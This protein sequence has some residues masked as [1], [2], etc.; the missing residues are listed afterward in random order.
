MLH[1]TAA[2][3]FVNWWVAKPVSKGGGQGRECSQHG[4]PDLQEFQKSEW[5]PENKIPMEKLNHESSKAATEQMSVYVLTIAYSLEDSPRKE[6]WGLLCTRLGSF[7]PL[8][9]EEDSNPE[10]KLLQASKPLREPCI[11]KACYKFRHKRPQ[12]SRGRAPLRHSK[13]N[14]P[15]SSFWKSPSNPQAHTH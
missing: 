7:R 8:N 6:K 9:K 13:N 4:F 12:E 14:Q 5:E 3:L 15:P 10:L 11:P 1:V 2:M